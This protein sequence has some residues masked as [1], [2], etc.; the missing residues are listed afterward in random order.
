MGKIIKIVCRI[1]E[2]MKNKSYYL[3]G[4]DENKPG[5]R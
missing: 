4:G 3:Y 2:T 5:F 1:V